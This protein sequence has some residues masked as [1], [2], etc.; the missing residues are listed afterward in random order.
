[1]KKVVLAF[2]AML[3]ALS[4]FAQPRLYATAGYL[5]GNA[6]TKTTLLS[7][8]ATYNGFY[9]GVGYELP[10][11]TNVYLFAEV[12]YALQSNKDADS[13]AST[14]IHAVNI[15]LRVKYKYPI[16]SMF[17]VFGYGGVLTNIGL[18]AN[19]KAG[20]LSYSLYGEDGAMNRF[21][22]KLGLGGGVEISKKFAVDAG[23]DW[24]MF[25]MSKLDNTTTKINY[26]HVGVS[27]LF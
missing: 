15:P 7:G 4:A 17:S 24:G 23:Y 9:A 10:I 18:A 11:A 1:M 8:T 16:N 26:F 13:D 20:N 6:S 12:E 25:N 22:T 21:D 19:S 27:Y 3:L 14:T 2:A 5:M